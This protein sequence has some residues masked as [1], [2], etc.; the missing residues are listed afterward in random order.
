MNKRQRLMSSV[1]LAVAMVS[2]ATLVLAQTTSLPG[3]SSQGGATA[4]FIHAS[5]DSPRVD[6]LIDGTA[7]FT[8]VGS[9]DI[10]DYTPVNTGTHTVTLQTH[11]DGTPLLT[12]SVSFT[13]TDYTLAVADTSPPDFFQFVDDNR[14]PAP[15][16][17]RGRLVHLSPDAPA[18][19]VALKHGPVVISDLGYGEAS[20]YL[21]LSAGTYE[22]E[23]LPAGISYSIPVTLIVRPNKVYSVFAI[24]SPLSP[25]I[26]QT[27]DRDHGYEVCLPLVIRQ[28]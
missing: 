24:G 22:L 3:L 9:S 8:D 15:G 26:V 2:I 13:A 21:E 20:D 28:G 25:Q 17:A 27:V 23:I 18:V 19:D 12:R 10:T 6:L 7:V 1:V 4:R 16:M 11:G 5:P 14:A